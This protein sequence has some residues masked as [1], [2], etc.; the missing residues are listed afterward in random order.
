MSVVAMAKTVKSYL[1]L[2]LT[3]VNS[4]IG[5]IGISTMLYSVWMDRVWQR[6]MEDSSDVNK[7]SFLWCPYGDHYTVNGLNAQVRTCRKWDPC[8]HACAAI[9]DKGLE[10]EDLVDELYNT[11]AYKRT[12]NPMIQP[13]NEYRM[14][15]P[16]V[17]PPVDYKQLGKPKNA[18]KEPD[19]PKK[20]SNPNKLS[21]KGGHDSPKRRQYRKKGHN[22]RTYTIR[23]PESITTG[24]QGR[25]Q[26]KGRGR[27]MVMGHRIASRG[28]GMGQVIG[29]QGRG[30]RHGIS[31]QGKG[32][33]RGIGRQGRGTR[34]GRG[35]GR[36]I[37][38]QGKG[39][40]QDIGR[41]GKGIGQGIN[42]QG[43]GKRQDIGRQ[44]R[45]TNFMPTSQVSVGGQTAV[46]SSQQGSRA[47]HN[48]IPAS[49]MFTA[50]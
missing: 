3:L 50:R 36:G 32:K 48:F 40:R 27:G 12:Y 41:H 9:H 8:V 17:L 5:I 26:G 37:S 42:G 22:R 14:G 29:G 24:G 34:Q 2:F 49:F 30:K 10:P 6:D 45:G 1:Q 47:S 19:E 31:R 46:T 18:R 15:L 20:P 16:S 28:K 43:M 33:R 25:G 4:I 44:D 13:M 35:I 7:F 38:R 11:E 21:K 23:L 39:K